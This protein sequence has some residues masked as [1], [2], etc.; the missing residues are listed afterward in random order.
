MIL[1]AQLGAE[2]TWRGETLSP[3]ALA[4]LGALA[5]LLGVLGEDGDVL[6]GPSPV[7]GASVAPGARAWLR[8][9]PWIALDRVAAHPPDDV[10]AW[11]AQGLAPRPGRAAG[12]SWR[13]RLRTAPRAD[14]ATARHV[15]GRRWLHDERSAGHLPAHPFAAWIETPAA[16]E[17]AT[18]D[19]GPWVLKAPH[20]AAGRDRV[21][22]TSA[23]ATP[24]TRAHVQSA[25]AAWGGGLLEAWLVRHED[26]G[27]IGIVTDTA[28][29]PG[30]VHRLVTGADGRFRGIARLR[31]SGPPTPLAAALARWL[32]L[33]GARLQAAGY[34][35]PY[36]IDGYAGRDAQGE[37]H[38]VAVGEVNARMTFGHL[39]ACLFEACGEDARTFQRLGL[40]A[41]APASLP[42]GALPLLMAPD[43][44]R[45]IAWLQGDEAA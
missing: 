30:P 32:P 36:G 7:R 34:R 11:C 42:A 27:A 2:A 40:G 20:G 8:D 19:L 21:L 12:T 5:P 10:V 33:V 22:L 23:R 39:A 37:A 1:V 25:L 24:A 38:I 15:H 31:P 45:V 28:V 17:R 43:G 3:D 29:V 14:E 16:L 35:G 44:G 13:E 41:V 4:R 6:A 9:L 18:Q 26:A